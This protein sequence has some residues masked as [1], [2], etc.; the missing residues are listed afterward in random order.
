M[1][2]YNSRILLPLGLAAG[3][4]GLVSGGC[5]N[6]TRFYG[7]QP[8]S[9]A[10]DPQ[11]A[12]AQ[13]EG[14][15]GKPRLLRRVGQDFS[16]WEHRG[17]LY[18]LGVDS[19]A[20]RELNQTGELALAK[21]FFGAGPQGESVAVE[22]SKSKHEYADRLMERFSGQPRLIE[23]RCPDYFLWKERGRFVVLGS[24]ESSL[25][26]ESGRGLPGTRAVI[27]GGPQGETVI[28]EEDSWHPE[29]LR[30]LAAAFFGEGNIPAGLFPR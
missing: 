8:A 28:L 3:L 21:T 14:Q 20:E 6:A 13:E 15:E 18:V 9:L 25:R 1:H 26:Y 7:E 16:V 11:A 10:C 5:A 27:G 19:Q 30:R 12:P 2:S 23:K 24:A 17:R 29:L 22:V 4:L